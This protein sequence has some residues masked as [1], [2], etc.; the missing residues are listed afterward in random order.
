MYNSRAVLA[1]QA[2]ENIQKLQG[3]E[4]QS[5]Y[6]TAV[7]YEKQRAFDA[8][9]IYY[10]IVVEDYARSPWA[11]KALSKLHALEKKDEKK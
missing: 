8:A 5:Y 1:E 4:A 9:R 3:R 10:N 6:D 7:F 2:E 11:A